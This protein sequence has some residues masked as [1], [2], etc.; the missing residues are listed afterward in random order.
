MKI[1]FAKDHEGK[2]CQVYIAI[3][4]DANFIRKYLTRIASEAYRNKPI[5]GTTLEPD[6]TCEVITP[7]WEGKHC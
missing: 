6:G 7:M 4:G 2:P 5:Q 1:D 3:S